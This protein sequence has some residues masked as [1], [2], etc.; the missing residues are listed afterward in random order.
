MVR[1]AEARFEEVRLLSGIFQPLSDALSQSTG[2]RLS[3]RG[4]GGDCG[5]LCLACALAQL[6]LLSGSAL[7][8]VGSH[9][10]NGAAARDQ[11]FAEIIRAS[12]CAHGR[13]LSTQMAAVVDDGGPGEAPTI[14]QSLLSSFSA[15]AA[16]A[17]AD[18]FGKEL[19][20]VDT[21]L[22][23]MSVGGVPLAEPPV[24]GTYMDS[25]AFILTADLYLLRIIVSVHGSTGEELPGSPQTFLPRSGVDPRA[26]VR[27]RCHYE[28]HFV[29]EAQLALTPAL[30]RPDP[31]ALDAGCPPARCPSYGTGCSLQQSDRV[32]VLAANF[33]QLQ[34]QQLRARFPGLLAGLSDYASCYNRL[35]RADHS[36][37][38][39]AE[40]AAAWSGNDGPAGSEKRSRDSELAASEKKRCDAE[41]ADHELA[42][43]LQSSERR[44]MRRLLRDETTDPTRISLIY[45]DTSRQRQ[46]AR[47]DDDHSLDHLVT[48]D[49]PPR[50]AVCSQCGGLDMYGGTMPC[51]SCSGSFCHNCFPRS[52]HDPCRVI[53]PEQHTCE[54][55]AYT[56]DAPPP[57]IVH[58]DCALCSDDPSPPWQDP[59]DELMPPAHELG[60]AVVDVTPLSLPDSSGTSGAAAL[61]RADAI[62]DVWL[63]DTF[64]G[65]EGE[66]H[67]ALLPLPLSLSPPTHSPYWSLSTLADEL[68]R[69]S[70]QEA[71]VTYRE[72]LAA[73][74]RSK[75]GHAASADEVQ[76]SRFV[77]SGDLFRQYISESSFVEDGCPPYDSACSLLFG[78][79][80]RAG[81]AV[82][83]LALGVHGLEQPAQA[84]SE[85]A[86]PY[87]TSA[88]CTAMRGIAEE[89]LGLTDPGHVRHATYALLARARAAGYPLVHL[90]AN[91]LSRHRSFALYA[92]DFFKGGVDGAVASFCANA[93][94]SELVLVPL[95]G[96]TGLPGEDEVVDVAGRRHRLRNGRH[97]GA[98]RVQ[99]M[100]GFLP[101]DIDPTDAHLPPPQPPKP[102]QPPRPPRSVSFA[103]PS[104]PAPRGG[105]SAG[106]QGNDGAG[107]APGAGASEVAPGFAGASLLP[108]ARR[109]LADFVFPLRSLDDVR[110]LLLCRF[111]APTDL[112][113]FEFSGAVRQSL[114]ANGRRALSV[115]WRVCDVGGMHA[116]LDVRDVVE[117][118]GWLRVF[119]FPPCF[120]QLRA[121]RDCLEAKIAD[122]RAFWGCAMVLWCCCVTASLLVVEQP[123]TIV[124]D[125]VP[126]AFTQFRTSCFRDSPD[127]F[128][129]LF[130]RNAA[131]HP[132]YAAD[133]SARK[134]P[135]HHLAYASS[136]ARDRAKSTWT[137]FENLCRA[138][139]CLL[140]LAERPPAPMV[141][142]E[143]IERFAV[144]WYAAGHP[145]P[146]GYDNERAM[147]PPGA[148]RYQTFRG[149]GDG[150]VPPAVVPKSV[151]AA[152]VRGGDAPLGAPRRTGLLGGAR[153]DRN[154]DLLMI[155]NRVRR[156]DRAGVC[157]YDVTGV[158]TVQRH[159]F[160]ATNSLSG[161]I[162]C[163][164]DLAPRLRRDVD[165]AIVAPGEWQL[166][167]GS[168]DIE[169]FGPDA[170]VCI[171]CCAQSTFKPCIICNGGVARP[172]HALV[173]E[174]GVT[175]ILLD[176]EAVSNA[177]PLAADGAP[178]AHRTHTLDAEDPLPTLD[179]RLAAEAAV[180]LVFVSV[181]LRPLVYAHV[182]GFT[183]HGIVLPELDTRTS[184]VHAAQSIVTTVV[185]ATAASAFLV[186]EY[187]G[188]AR[189][190]VAPLDFRPARHLMCRSRKS[191]LACL[192]SGCT[193]MWCTLAALAGTPTGD[194][195]A[196][197]VLACEAY[198][199]PGHMLADFP[200][201]ALIAPLAFRIGAMAATSVLSRP[202]LDH[203]AS[204]PA[205]RAIADSARQNQLL[206]DALHAASDDELLA[207]WVDRI[208]PID[209]TDV[210]ASLLAALPGFDEPGLEAQPYTP[211]Y[212]PYD[213][214]W[215]PLPPRQ[216][217]PSPD[218]PMCVR[219][220]FDMMV[221]ATQR[222]VRAWII[223][224]LQDL[225]RIR[226]AVAEGRE[227]RLASG[228]ERRDRPRAF[229]VGQL[230]LHPWARGRV[231]DCRGP[232]CK[233]LDF[234]API[235]T[236]L[237]LA[238]LRERLADYPDQYFVANLLEG[239]RLD[240]DVELQ[241]VFVP[242]LVSLP[243]GYKAVGKELRRMRKLGWYDFFP[244]FPFWPM[245][246]NAQGSTARKLEPGRDRRTTE[247]SGPRMP[248]F[249]L[250]G[251]AAISINA[252]SFMYH[253]PQ[254]FISDTRPEML[255]WLRARGL[256][257]PSSVDE[258]RRTVSKWHKELKP[259]LAR[260]MRD[261]A[262][263]KRAG[264]IF[265]VPVYGYGDDA[266]DY[267]NQLAMAECELHKLGIV[268]LAEPGDLSDLPPV[269][270]PFASDQLIFISE[271]RLGFGTHGASN[272]AQRFSEALL[273]LFR[274]DMDA[275]E[276]PF[277]DGPTP[278]MRQWLLARRK[279]AE[280]LA[281]AEQAA[282]QAQSSCMPAPT[283]DVVERHFQVQRRLYTVF[284][285]TDDPIWIVVDVDRT[286]RALRVWRRLTNAVN[287]IMAIPE[288]RHLGVQILWLGVLVMISLGIVVVPKAKLLRAS[289][290]VAQVL[291]GGQP[292]HVYRSLIGLLEHLRAVNL[293]G[294]NVMH[295][296]YAP[297]TPTGASRFGPDGRV[298]CDAL[299]LAQL[300]RWQTLLR[301]S[302]GVSVRRAF[303]R[304][305]VEPSLSTLTVFG[306]SDACFGDAEPNGIGG[307]CHGLYWQFSVPT[308]DDDVLSTPVLEF[309]GVAFNIIALAA[310]VQ[311]LLGAHGT[312]LLRTDAL[313]T[314]LVLPR[315]SQKS[316]LLVDA[317]HFLA[318]T[319]EWQR[320]APILRIQHIFGDTMAMSDPL[321]RG[322]LEE[323]RA[324]CRQLG[325][326]PVLV[327][328]PPQCRHIYDCVVQLERARRLHAQRI[329]PL[330]S[331]GALDDVPYVMT[332]MESFGSRYGHNSCPPPLP[333]G[334]V[335]PATTDVK[336]MFCTNCGKP[337]TSR[338]T[339]LYRVG[340]CYHG[341]CCQPNPAC[342]YC[343]GGTTTSRARPMTLSAPPTQPQ[344]FLSQLGAALGAPAPAVGEASA[345]PASLPVAGLLLPTLVLSDA[346]LARLSTSRLA[347]AAKTYAHA[348][349]L[350]L[351]SGGSDPSMALRCDV[352]SLCYAGEVMTEYSE[353]GAN[354]NTLKKDDRA[355][356]FWE[357][358][359]ERVGTNPMRTPQEVRENPERQA[360][361]LAI[362]MLYAS[363]VCVPK[364]PGRQCIKPRSALA[365]PL[366]IIRI[367]NRWGVPMPGYKALQ[368]QFLG[369]SRAYLA[370]HGPKSLAPKRAEPMRFSMVRT[371]NNIPLD[372]SVYVGKRCW[373]ENDHTVFMFRRLNVISI[374]AATR[375][376]EW[377][378]HLSNTTMFTVRSDLWWLINKRIVMDPTEAELHSLKIGDIAYAAPPLAKSD[379]LGEIHCPFPVV[380]PFNFDAD[381]AAAAFRDIELRCPCHGEDRKTRAVIADEAGNP[382]T[383]AVLD[384]I[385][386]DVL[387]YLYG[388]A[389]ASLFSWHSYRSGLCCALFAAGCPDAVNQLI[390]RWMCPESLLAYRR[391]GAMQY[392]GWIDKAAAAVVDTI[393]SGNAPRVD[394][395]ASASEL[396]TY[397][398]NTSRQSPLMR[399]WVAETNPQ[400][401][402]PT[403]AQP[404]ATATPTPANPTLVAPDL[405]PIT[406]ANAVGRRVLVPAEIYPQYKCSEHQGRG[407]ECLAMTA[408]AQTV[409]VRFTF[410]RT[411]DGRPYEDERLPMSLLQ[412]M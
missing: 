136:D 36:E 197:A 314:A 117:L 118:G 25:G 65:N 27:L 277:F 76:A 14:A 23:L 292:F 21:Y 260:L 399:E 293:Q 159:A 204:P 374:R 96:L 152:L 143:E 411:A 375:L 35:V 379:Q 192:A 58:A 44:E 28:Q 39:L 193:F 317:F 241:S 48:G 11:F 363:A 54:R 390:C 376:A 394:H 109:E 412:P 61:P 308:R 71:A 169:P 26:E 272:L 366:A 309:L 63:N 264:Y 255:A 378:W 278:A 265:N 162:D 377:V 324:R 127:K 68:R 121:D 288:K 370:Y 70:V 345:A 248:T 180:L 47:A 142:G 331:G 141:F 59:T 408:T 90:G 319:E 312:F 110:R 167:P 111:I 236:H 230:E 51:P 316:P 7:E 29:L 285:Y 119:L 190:T 85:L 120:Q 259:D 227:A 307:F 202:L 18:A 112:V 337:N 252:A 41:R 280:S 163:R 303:T 344:T 406:H 214:P 45:A 291:A 122:C 60:S 97:L 20:A 16:Y 395:D 242:H 135:L 326:Q 247:G 91:P 322:R 165:A 353:F 398:G 198:I 188:G 327:D 258:L 339:G 149:P 124:A 168:R 158:D 203:V 358:V 330:V 107:G 220:P 335:A 139:A 287:L 184:C 393:Q 95:S 218:A 208:G 12:I 15:W 355:W 148:R 298:H 296:L 66:A 126:Y 187:V 34:E 173:M 22:A 283:A 275:A 354:A 87:D 405:T 31:A 200:P 170:Y 155:G 320:L 368:A 103:P 235:N 381:N 282:C 130:V 116:V 396:F 50:I 382:Y 229:A 196:R 267:F 364:T 321:S 195:A 102:P 233:M 245:Y 101:V 53:A 346:A 397:M 57:A 254:H 222:A 178:R 328:L 84:F 46:L 140:P 391:L 161:R 42:V 302:A 132:P 231:W 350:A 201:D 232:C 6:G 226:L 55:C 171:E 342:F 82:V 234:Q 372:G 78:F 276:G 151:V 385:L 351:S 347:I 13:C 261:L 388:K 402:Q 238:Y 49:E 8:S 410:A 336:V 134:P 191:R 274:L 270:A 176:A 249:D 86:E 33:C 175:T 225:V 362:L 409:K 133:A 210:P 207:G 357:H 323:F 147:P 153:G 77:S 404:A 37:R 244:D 206:I 199:K 268:F 38:V 24:V 352:A 256:P 306:C 137:T 113:G 251:L 313:T 205:W 318:L 146:A 329:T 263:L 311:S 64:V 304:A 67:P 257:P 80:P 297:H 271:L 81:R 373:H 150:R 349:S 294:R 114:E 99:F 129:R 212:V 384:R 156:M 106:D 361:L 19:L 221:P 166:M 286:L 75:A 228:E 125:F 72:M 392:Q 389:F 219:S 52:E 100:R 383:H 213:T 209:P 74:A 9:V 341:V 295:G 179:V 266:R 239:A 4:G 172:G 400:T 186:G 154:H 5:F 32:T 269:G 332:F 224:A 17:E 359:C 250:S 92:A 217:D 3:D 246:L 338:C 365:Y 174:G 279:V 216:P 401:P 289:S 73:A 105:S 115:D 88:Q 131:V 98:G 181:L 194:A 273:H 300:H 40:L 108:G 348:R 237:N 185:G 157:M 325:I 144:N 93:E 128:V 43:S 1:L 340:G 2:Y 281:A 356:E 83:I 299:M 104:D 160:I 284:M 290:T 403:A 10:F 253:M 89:L 30:A 123:D 240:A 262:V 62:S 371:I 360:W 79:S 145:V 183:M 56:W 189:L 94:I 215:L 407:W 69:L 164:I 333:P 387:E 310:R 301:H 334:Y 386:K 367:F 211:V 305:E 138:L 343:R 315:E 223:H 369:L 380:F 243:R 177:V 182:N